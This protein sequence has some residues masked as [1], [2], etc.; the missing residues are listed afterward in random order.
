MHVN[1]RRIP[2]AA[3]AV[4]A[5]AVGIV[6]F[7]I[8]VLSPP[9]TEPADR[10]ALSGAMAGLHFLHAQ[11][12]YPGPELPPERYQRAW[13]RTRPLIAAGRTMRAAITGY[14]E[15][16][17][18]RPIGPKN[19]GGR[20]IALA[21][22]P[23]D[24]D[25][26]L[27][28]AASGGLWRSDSAGVGARAWRYVD[29]GYPVLGVNAIAIDPADTARVYIGTGE[30]YGKETSIGGLYIR[31][32]RGSYGI[33]ILR[34]S[35]GGA[36]W[37]KCLDWSY[38]QRRG[39]LALDIDPQD[40]SRIFAGTSEG[41]YRS[42]DRGDTWQQVL[43]IPMAV[44]LAIHP[45]RPDTIYASC[46]NLGTPADAGIWRTTDGGDTWNELTT[47]L[48]ATWTGKTMLDI[49]RTAPEVIYADVANALSDEDREGVDLYRSLDAGQTWE[50]LSSGWMYYP[51]IARYQGWFSHFVAVHPADSSQVVASGVY[52][53]VSTDGGR[54][55]H[56]TSHSDWYPGIT[57][58]GQPEGD[59][60]Y[61]HADI[62]CYARHPTN[63]DLLFFG[64]DG[65]V[66]R[67]TNF[68]WTFRGLNGGYQTTQF[69]G[70]FASA[71]DDSTVA[72]GGLQDNSTVIYRGYD[73][74][75]R[76]LGGDGGY[77][78][79]FPTDAETFLGSTQYG[80]IYRSTD[81]GDS[82]QQINSGM[83]NEGDVCFVAPFEQAETDPDLIY[84]GR[85]Q[86]WRSTD[87][88]VL[89]HVPG[90]ASPLD[91]NP[92]L[93]IGVY[94]RDPDVVWAATVPAV[95]RA[96][97]HRTTDGGETWQNV[98]GSLPD[99][100]PVDLQAG[101]HDDRDAYVILSGF[102]SSHLF[103]TS[104]AG[105]SWQDLDRGL[106][107][108]IPTS[109]LVID[110]FNSD[111]LYVGNDFGVWFSPD[112]GENWYPFTE[113]MPT[114]ALIMDLS[115]SR[116]NRALRAVTH[117]LGVWERPLV[118]LASSGDDDIED[119]DVETVA[120][121]Q[122]Y[123]NPFN[124]RTLIRYEL[125]QRARVRLALYDVRGRLVRT[126]VDG[127]LGA[128]VHYESVSSHNLRSGVY[129]YRLEVD[130]RA[131]TRK[132]LIVR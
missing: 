67:S 51:D 63:P 70:G 122:N 52:S 42:T 16:A 89:W 115:V 12:A 38:D 24:P 113:G 4:L 2:V 110:P 57:Q 108:D 116:D 114:G 41:V 60:N 21:I 9:P 10:H 66:F 99:R 102:G 14:E 96:G 104:D 62:H 15:P 131:L 118:R 34:T 125:P 55:F 11:R 77:S 5:A 109:A 105:S 49:Y 59:S 97:V 124:G 61:M 126:L 23:L 47:G 88:G 56:R 101:R 39:V 26:I 29:T 81:D 13:Q 31:T 91:R 43:S 19:V 92:I 83:R 75:Q 18:W 132:M 79:L 30:V 8:P 50:N 130:G 72:I 76:C 128:G 80:N 85:E 129:L 64:T 27:A 119:T 95:Q 40:S 48:P 28:G 112:D 53:Y 65:G 111:C 84:A 93:S 117:G 74:W 103:K 35:D 82:W 86:L 25:I 68:G 45:D 73:A 123:P 36:T 6:L 71:P 100:Y 7:I 54:T 78:G 69:Y 107:P 87:G 90:W 37:E 44:D 106:L 3:A 20:T 17:P 33:G 121:M 98:T 58:P 22:N 46:G 127:H 94:R 120:M 1:G 32:T